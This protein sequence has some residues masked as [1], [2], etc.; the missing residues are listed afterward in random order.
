MLAFEP[1]IAVI[2]DKITEVNG[3]IEKYQREGIG[4]KYFNAHLIN[5]DDK[6]NVHFSDLNLI[7]L[8]VH[9]TENIDDYDPTHCAAWIDSLVPEYSF[10]VLILWSKETDKKDE[11]LI[12]LA[13]INRS[14][15]ICI[16]KQKTDFK[17][18]DSWD[19][20]KLEHSIK[21]ELDKYP[22]IEELAMWKKS[23]LYSSN[24]IIGHLSKEI[25]PEILNKKLQKI[26][27]GHGGT[28]LL[29]ADNEK[30]KREVLFEALDNILISN[31]KSTR[32]EQSISEPNKNSLY[33]IASFPVTDIDSKLNSWFHFKLTEPP[34]EP[35]LITPG[36]ISYFSNISLRKNYNIQNDDTVLKYLKNQIDVEES[37]PKIYDVAVIVSRPCD[38]A[39]NKFGKNL[40]LLSGVLI[41]NPIRDKKSKFKGAIKQPLSIKLYDHL[42]I[43][44]NIVDCALIFD[45]R[46]SFSLPPEIYKERFNKLKIFNKELLSEIQVEYGAYSSI[47]GITQVI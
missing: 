13:K 32:P 41:E 19:F 43:S 36:L 18:D 15:F 11:V 23:I 12:E 44:K 21:I 22:E 25:T 2:D 37:K 27:I 35:N 14:P 38:V 40:K 29:G 34:L 31:S 39:Q 24:T 17:T 8:D 45:F 16:A 1:R 47:L 6:P 33:N 7:Y 10:Y 28:Y 20:E 30:Q 5:G 26:I 4:I 46:Y 3:I 42:S 9:F